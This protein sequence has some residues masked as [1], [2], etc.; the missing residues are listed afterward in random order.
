MKGYEFVCMKTRAHTHSL[1]MNPCR[2][3][4]FPV[5]ERPGLIISSWFILYSHITSEYHHVLR[6]YFHMGTAAACYSVLH[7]GV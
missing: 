1:K 6:M 3:L 5:W 2:G 7:V 4:S